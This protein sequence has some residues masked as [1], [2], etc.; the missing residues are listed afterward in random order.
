[1]WEIGLFDFGPA[2]EVRLRGR[3]S[4]PRLVNMVRDQLLAPELKPSEAS[5]RDHPPGRQRTDEA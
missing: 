5:Q 1:M 2:G 4:D 3:S